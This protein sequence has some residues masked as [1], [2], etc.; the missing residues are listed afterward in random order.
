M[1]PH[2]SDKAAET[3]ARLP[4]GD[5]LIRWFGAVP[6][7]HDAE[8]VELS[9]RRRA[10]SILRVHTWIT[11]AEVDQ[12]GY[13]VRDK[14]V[15]VAFALERIIDLQLEGF[16]GQNVIYGLTL[17]S[18]PERPERRPYYWLDPSPDDLEIELEPSFG[19]D[20][21]IRCQQVRIDLHPGLPED[22]TE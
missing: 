7:F 13:Y 6:T 10:P 19:L 1:M 20:G 8:I 2:D 17:R 5:D 14:H 21:T 16:S 4:G 15:V 11:R 12:R 22:A 9:L 3:L 18:A